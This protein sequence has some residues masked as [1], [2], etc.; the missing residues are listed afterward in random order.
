MNSS[1]ASSRFRWLLPTA[2]LSLV[3][4]QG[5]VFD[6]DDDEDQVGAVGYY[7]GDLV[8]DWTIEGD[9]D[10]F[11]CD[12]NRATDIVIDVTSISGRPIATFT[13]SC[14]LFEASVPLEEGDYA[15]SAALIDPDDFEVT[16]AVDLG[17]FSIYD[18]RETVVPIN[19]PLRSFR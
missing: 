10:P 7:E 12:E 11:D 1:R 8:V 13:Q 2:L 9:K 3:A 15:G 6:V 17:A 19:F 5:C 14:D 16:T 4:L 18:G